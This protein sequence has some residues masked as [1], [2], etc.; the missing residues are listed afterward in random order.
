MAVNQSDTKDKDHNDAEISIA[1]GSIPAGFVKIGNPP[2]T[3]EVIAQQN[4]YALNK[5]NQ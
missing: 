2:N 4:V 5:R 1:T 3:S